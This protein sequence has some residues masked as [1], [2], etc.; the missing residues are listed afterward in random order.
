MDKEDYIENLERVLQAIVDWQLP[1]TGKFWPNHDGT[2]SDRPM[3]YGAAWG[4]NGERDYF[5]AMAKEALG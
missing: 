3:S 1:A 5:R 4:S 2:D